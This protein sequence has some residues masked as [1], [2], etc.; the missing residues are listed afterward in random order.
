MLDLELEAP[1]VRC[2]VISATRI[3]A[4][5]EVILLGIHQICAQ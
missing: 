3:G 5:G 1:F 4:G 2:P